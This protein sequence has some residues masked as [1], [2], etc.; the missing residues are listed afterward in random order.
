MR[1][2]PDRDPNPPPWYEEEDVEYT[3]S[4]RAQLAGEITLTLPPGATQKQV[5]Q[6]LA[7]MAWL[8]ADDVLLQVT[9]ASMDNIIV[10]AVDGPGGPDP[11]DYM[12]D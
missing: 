6:A 1:D 2:I 11:Y 4:F 7:H 9:C 8:T 12:E 10:E 5:Q 3:V